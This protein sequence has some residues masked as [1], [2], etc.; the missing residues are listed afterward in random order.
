MNNMTL[1]AEEVRLGNHVLYN[2]VPHVVDRLIRRSIR[3]IP[4]SKGMT[5]D[6]YEPIPLTE[7]WLEKFGFISDGV[8]WMKDNIAIGD[9]KSGYFYIPFAVRIAYRHP[10]EIKYVHRLQNLY[11]ALRDEE[12]T[13]KEE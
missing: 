3:T 4:A 5:V 11:F 7:E 12:L 6:D 8:V 1:K 2:G 10:N 13:L 9:Y